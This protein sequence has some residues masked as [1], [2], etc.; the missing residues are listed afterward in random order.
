M[1]TDRGLEATR[2]IRKKISHEHGNDPR[3]LVEYYLTYQARFADHLRRG[4]ISD[5]GLGESAEQDA[6]A[7]L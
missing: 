6:A 4:L 7:E 3:R 5:R 2:A 1:S